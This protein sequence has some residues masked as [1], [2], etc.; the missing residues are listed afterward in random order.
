MLLYYMFDSRVH[1]YEI[2]TEQ[3]VETNYN[4]LLMFQY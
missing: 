4:I 3:K 1:K 2:Y